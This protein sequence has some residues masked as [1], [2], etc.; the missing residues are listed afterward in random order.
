[1]MILK[2]KHRY[3]GNAIITMQ[4]LSEA[5]KEGWSGVGVGV[6]V[7]KHTLAKQTPHLK[8]PMHEQRR[9]VTE[10]PP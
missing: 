5:P 2:Y 10:E 9:A 6:G 4:S 8:T 3:P 7:K 1:M